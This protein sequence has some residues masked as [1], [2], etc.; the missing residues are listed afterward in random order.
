MK[1][2]QLHTLKLL[3]SDS[4]KAFLKRQFDGVRFVFN[5]YLKE[6]PYGDYYTQTADLPWLKGRE[7]NEF[8]KKVNSQ[9][10]IHAVRWE[11]SVY[12]K[13]R[14]G[15]G[16]LQFMGP[17]D[18]KFTM[19]QGVYVA[20]NKLYI[21]KLRDGIIIEDGFVCNDRIVECTIELKINLVYACYLL[22]REKKCN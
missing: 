19:N 14:R 13:Y 22:T 18:C 4:Q 3:P 6:Q 11:N 20:D 12:S 9:S 5:H 7:G 21:P 16:P 1:D 2:S 10:L 8:L 15:K 17:Y